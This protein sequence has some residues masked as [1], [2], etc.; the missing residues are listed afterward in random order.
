MFSDSFAGI[1]P[2]SLPGFVV[3]E[4]C[5]AAVAVLAD[6]VLGGAPVAPVVAPA[7][8]GPENEASSHV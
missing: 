4:V 3:A 1:S 2:A 5:G 7:E 8:R 6:R